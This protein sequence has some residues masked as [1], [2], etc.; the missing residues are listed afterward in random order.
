MSKPKKYFSAN[1]RKCLRNL[2]HNLVEPDQNTLVRQ[3]SMINQTLCTRASEN[4]IQAG[5]V[6]EYSRWSQGFS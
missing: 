4:F 3:L 5:A 1:H 6:V 2:L